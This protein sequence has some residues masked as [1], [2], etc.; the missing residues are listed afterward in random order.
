[1]IDFIKSDISW[2]DV[3]FV[4]NEVQH[5]IPAADPDVY[6]DRSELRYYLEIDIP[7]Y[8]QSTNFETLIRLEGREKP[9]KVSGGSN[10]YE[11]CSFRIESILAGFLSITKPE[12]GQTNLSII[13]SLTSPYQL[14]EIISPDVSNTPLPGRVAMRAGLALRDFVGYGHKFFS[15]AKNMQF[16]T[17]QP[18]G[19][20][21]CP[22]QEEYLYFL[23]NLSPF[24][25]S[26]NLRVRVTYASGEREVFTK[27]SMQGALANQVVCCP[28]G[29][30]ALGLTA[31][32][33]VQYEVWLSDENLFRFSQVRTFIIDRRQYRYQRFIL[34]ANSFG[35]FDTL[36]LLGKSVEESDVTKS[37]S[38]QEREVGHGLSYSELAI[39]SVKENSGIQ[40]STGFFDRDQESYLSYLR[41]LMLSECILEDT[42]FGYEALN[43]ITQNIAFKQDDP[44]L[45]ERTFQFRRTYSDTN[46]SRLAPVA[47]SSTRPVGW[48]GVGN[49]Y[50][51]DAFG[52]RTGLVKA[53]TLR[54]YYTDTGRDFMP[55]TQKPNV[56]G[57][58][59]YLIPSPDIA[60][61][62]GTT[63]YPSAV[64]T[65]LGT[66]V[67]NN[68]GPGEDGSGAVI[69]VPAGM[70]GGEKAGDSDILA[71]AEW[72]RLDTQA[73][74]NANGSCEIAENYT[75]PVPEGFFHYRTNFPSRVS[76]AHADGSGGADKGNTQALQSYSGPYIFPVGSND[77]DFP[78]EIG[79]YFGYQAQAGETV[80]CEVFQN[81]VLRR[82]N[83]AAYTSAGYW[84]GYL[85]A[86][87]SHTSLYE[88]A[89]GDKFLIKLTFL[90]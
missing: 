73:Y 48:R 66:K 36:R 68:C 43:L 19:K 14:R 70:F 38:A 28:V 27:K 1:M 26:I 10:I 32:D 72:T 15:R 80:K 77:L 82:S 11:G 24:P 12:K 47:P 71:E 79:Y 2:L 46:F 31:A 8:P 56:E 69:T 34:F 37:T 85:F 39:I 87:S 59:D 3:D 13:A 57:D 23:L 75:W 21:V 22:C 61:V 67:R 42:A 81:G 84:N 18:D 62:P 44:G 35:G 76:L 54:K 25:T 52:K 20:Q 58:P 55:L 86:N 90:S 45:I 88:P 41:E 78:V 6:T 33:I 53:T 89:S 4:R 74:A 5:I 49:R 29:P 30:T 50:L 17:W 65:R 51:L 60:V 63:P 40:V 83:T 7:E 64:I 16:L 9:I